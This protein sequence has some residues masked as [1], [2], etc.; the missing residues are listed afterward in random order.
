M[1]KT[2]HY[3]CF[4]RYILNYHSNSMIVEKYRADYYDS[5]N[6]KFDSYYGSC[7]YDLKNNRYANIR[8]FFLNV[9]EEDADKEIDKMVDKWEEFNKDSEV[10]R[11]DI[12]FDEIRQKYLNVID[13]YERMNSKPESTEI[14]M[15][16]ILNL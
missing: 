8:N 2:F 14:P 6:D 11:C 16:V 12:D 4:Q 3:A 5:E 10:V 13:K 15:H 9:G 1:F 7:V